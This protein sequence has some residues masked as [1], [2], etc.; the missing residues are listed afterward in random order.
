MADVP[1]N[2]VPARHPEQ[3]DQL[4]A[5]LFMHRRVTRPGQVHHITGPADH[6]GGMARPFHH[7]LQVI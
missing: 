2:H 1:E 4:P 6:R 5:L 7:P 3:L